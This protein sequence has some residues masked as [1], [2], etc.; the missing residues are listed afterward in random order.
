MF[1]IMPVAIKVN[2][3]IALELIDFHHAEVL[4]QLVQDNRHYLRAWLPWVDYM[5]SV[6]DFRKYI[7]S[8][9]QRYAS[10]Q[11]IGYVIMLAHAMVGRIGLYNVDLHNKNASIG[12]WVA[13][14][15]QGKGVITQ[16]C[17]AVIEHCFTNLQLRRIEIRAGVENHKSQ[18][19]PLR[20]GFTQEGLVRQ[21]EFLNDHFIDLYVYSL[22]KEEWEKH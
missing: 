6:D 17:Q 20:L 13:E 12:Y 14:P 5:R 9:K 10:R 19:I 18:A 8:S 16:C 4:Y 1:L 15:W 2:D 7:T 11:E 21:G 3:S 22:L